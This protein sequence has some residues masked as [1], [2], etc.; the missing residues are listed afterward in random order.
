MR[1]RKTYSLSYVTFQQFD[2]AVGDDAQAFGRGRDKEGLS[3][4]KRLAM[5]IGISHS[6]F[7]AKTDEDDERVKS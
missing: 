4:A 6:A 5:A 2:A 1:S 3:L 7:A